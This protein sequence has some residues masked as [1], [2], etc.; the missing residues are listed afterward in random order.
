MR[1]IFAQNL[2]TIP[3]SA[4]EQ[5]LKF[6]VKLVNK[7]AASAT[8]L[9]K[10]ILLHAYSRTTASSQLCQHKQKLLTAYLTS[11]HN[12]VLCYKLRTVETENP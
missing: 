3:A 8:Q 7:T 5:I 9:A 2:R 1:L 6:S 12:S 10:G 4:E 11:W